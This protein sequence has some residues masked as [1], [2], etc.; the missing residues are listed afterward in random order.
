MQIGPYLLPSP[1]LLA[2]M[3]GTSEPPFRRMCLELGAG[4]AP[5][6]GLPGLAGI[7]RDYFMIGGCFG[8]DKIAGERGQ[9]FFHHYNAM[10]AE[11]SGK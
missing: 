10:T 8:A 9:L 2:P 3:A 7:Y 1:T 4:A 6:L 5:D 11:N